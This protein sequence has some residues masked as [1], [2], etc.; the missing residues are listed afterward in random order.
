MLQAFMKLARHQTFVKPAR[1]ALHCV[2]GV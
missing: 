2:N 1:R